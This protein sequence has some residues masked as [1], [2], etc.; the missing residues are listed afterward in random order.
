[1][2]LEERVRILEEQVRGLIS[3]RAKDKMYTDA[4]INGTRQSVANIT[5]WTQTKKA[6]IDDTEVV[7]TDVPNGNLTVYC[8]VAYSVVRSATEVTVSFAP[9]EEV[10]DV[11]ISIL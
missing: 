10:I 6:Y 8:D 2:N 11:T 9:L 1:M 4:D 7:F 3:A 5:P